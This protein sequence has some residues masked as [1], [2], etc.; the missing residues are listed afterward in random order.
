MVSLARLFGDSSA[1]DFAPDD[2]WL[3]EVAWAQESADHAALGIFAA[4]RG[5]LPLAKYKQLAPKYGLTFTV[6]PG[7]ELRGAPVMQPVAHLHHWTASRPSTKNPAPALRICIDG[8]ADLDG[9]LSNWHVDF[10]GRA[11]FLATGRANHA[12]RGH[13][14]LLDRMRAGL[15]P[16]G[17]AAKLRLKDTGGF[18]GALIGTEIE[19]SGKGELTWAQIVT[20]ARLDRML[21]E[22]HG[23]N[24]AQAAQ[25]AHVNTTRRKIDLDPGNMARILAAFRAKS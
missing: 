15:P 23:F 21:A 22:A 7:A 6:A 3:D 16:K 18:G 2:S 9:P 24:E 25:W 13:Q 4:P 19:H 10:L 1:G 11:T 8:R 5:R 20:V 17:H 12:G 14:A